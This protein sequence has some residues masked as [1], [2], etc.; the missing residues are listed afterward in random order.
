MCR[1][2]YITCFHIVCGAGQKFI[3]CLFCNSLFIE[4][5][6]R[7]RNI[8]SLG[9][10][11]RCLRFQVKVNR[12]SHSQGNFIQTIKSCCRYYFPTDNVIFTLI[13]CG[14]ALQFELQIYCS[15]SIFRIKCTQWNQHLS[16]DFLR[17]SGGNGLVGTYGAC[18]IRIA[19]IIKHTG[20]IA[21][22]KKNILCS[23][24]THNQRSTNLQWN[25]FI[26]TSVCLTGGTFYFKLN[27]RSIFYPLVAYCHFNICKNTGNIIDRTFFQI[28]S[29]CHLQVIDGEFGFLTHHDFS[30]AIFI[31][32]CAQY[33]RTGIRRIFLYFKIDV[34]SC[35]VT[36]KCTGGN[37]IR[38]YLL[39]RKDILFHFP[40]GKFCRLATIFSTCLQGDIY[41]VSL[42][43]ANRHISGIAEGNTSG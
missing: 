24:I 26:F 27:I 32:R 8:A 41:R 19:K 28:I 40:L 29:C 23:V 12:I 39:P 31:I 15:D 35:D 10:I 22:S 2:R 6:L 4:F 38:S 33:F 11:H 5:H 42:A 1:H 14:T 7:Q 17:C 36:R 21:V 34:S 20:I 16:F 13:F 25:I 37:I 18:G 9:R 43:A 30:C 3:V